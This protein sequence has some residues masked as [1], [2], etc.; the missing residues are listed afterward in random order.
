MRYLT[1][2]DAACALLGYSR[3]ELRKMRVPQVCEEERARTLYQEMLR[4]NHQRGRVVLVC[5]DGRRIPAHY[6][7]HFT[8]VAELP[9][10]VSILFP[11]DD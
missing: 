1:A 9:Y 8:R 6:E 5:K 2:S 11:I 3:E 4:S 7:A 10:Y